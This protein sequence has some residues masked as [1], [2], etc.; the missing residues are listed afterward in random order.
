MN[1][2]Q[3]PGLDPNSLGPFHSPSGGISAMRVGFFICLGFAIVLSCVQV[4]LTVNKLG[5]VS[6]LIYAFLGGA[7]GG[8]VGQSFTEK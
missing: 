2:I 7:F 8:K 3:D 1:D 5:D 4:Y 6:G